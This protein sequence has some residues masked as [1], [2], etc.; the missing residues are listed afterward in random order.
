MELGV[1]FRLEHPPARL[2]ALMQQADGAGFKH[3]WVFDNPIAA[4][5]PYTLLALCAQAT[6]RLRLGTCVTNPVTRH[7]SVTASSLATLD[8]ISG[9]RMVL[10]IGRGDTAVR[11]I[12]QTAASLERF[13][14]SALAIR[15][16]S[17]GQEIVLDGVP[18]RLP[19]TPASPLPMW[20]AGYG[21][22]ILDIAARVADGVILQVGDPTILAVLIAYV[23]EREAAAGRPVGSVRVQVA[24]PAHVGTP[25][26]GVERC[27][28]YPRFLRHHLEAALA[29]WAERLPAG[30]VTSYRDADSDAALRD[31]VTRTCLIGG[32][33]DH[34]ERI[35]ALR[36]LGADQ[37]NLYLMDEG[38]REVIEAYGA[39]IV[40]A[41]S[42]PD[43]AAASTAARAAVPS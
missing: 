37:V 42:R 43:P 10:G 30:F 40:A 32:P 22:R 4:M 19:W 3:G 14:A 33:A 35:E 26:E 24:V 25:A 8:T 20:I 34:M 2:V 17:E 12:G 11:M 29:P 31:E 7:P 6:T 13:E 18:V 27:L 5:E 38:Q 39:D 41:V 28:W 23:R 9:G 15:G 16:L 21:P 36:A 1:T